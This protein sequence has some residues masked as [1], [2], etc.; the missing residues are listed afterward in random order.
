MSSHNDPEEATRTGSATCPRGHRVKF[1]YAPH[2]PSTIQKY[3]LKR[4]CLTELDIDPRTLEVTATRDANPLRGTVRASEGTYW[5]TCPV[6]GA[7][8]ERF[9]TV[10]DHNFGVC[11]RD[12][13]LVEAPVVPRRGDDSEDDSDEDSTNA[14]SDWGR[15]SWNATQRAWATQHW[16]DADER[17]WASQQRG[18]RNSSRAWAPRTTYPVTCSDCGRSAEV[19]FRPTEGRP[20]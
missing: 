12:H 17:A 3:C 4:E 13:R 9:T 19:P 18:G 15:R 7:T 20:V 5:I 11:P 10:D 2:D 14:Q 16:N 1:R 8:F 6:H